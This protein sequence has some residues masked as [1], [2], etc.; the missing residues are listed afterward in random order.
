MVHNGKLYVVG[1]L[2]AVRL[3]D[4]NADIHAVDMRILDLEDDQ[5]ICPSLQH[6]PCACHNP[7]M[8]AHEYQLILFGGMSRL[9]RCNSM[10]QQ[11]FRRS[12]SV[13]CHKKLLPNYC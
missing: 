3:H 13:K 12:S 7:L 4:I 2:D 8:A 5:W 10:S 6:V 1:K 9:P 11:G